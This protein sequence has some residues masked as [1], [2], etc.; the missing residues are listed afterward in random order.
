MMDKKTQKIGVICSIVQIIL[1]FSQNLSQ[2]TFVS[3]TRFS[4]KPIIGAHHFFHFCILL[5]I[6]IISLY[7]CFTTYWL[8]S[9]GRMPPLII[10][11]LM[12]LKNNY[13]FQFKDLLEKNIRTKQAVRQC[14]MQSL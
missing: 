8:L 7:L 10:Y 1:S 9:T 3:T 4:F 12:Y 11:R 2:Q 5:P 13:A 6:L 14:S